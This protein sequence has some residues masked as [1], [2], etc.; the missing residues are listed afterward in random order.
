MQRSDDAHDRVPAPT[1]P[2]R[3]APSFTLEDWDAIADL[4]DA[5]SGTPDVRTA[6]A[7]EI[8]DRIT[9]YRR[10]GW[11]AAG[12]D[13]WPA[14]AAAIRS[15]RDETRGTSAAVADDDAGD[16]SGAARP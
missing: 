11:H 4:I 6:L 12:F 15:L 8:R 13:M 16:E 10:L 2:K 1:S 9:L 14:D 5:Q 3:A 7:K